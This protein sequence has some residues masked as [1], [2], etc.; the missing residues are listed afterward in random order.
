MLM[1]NTKPIHIHIP[2][3]LVEKLDRI[4]KDH[5]ENRTQTIIR[6]IKEYEE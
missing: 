6:I 1:N 5:Y 2:I 3:E 4:S